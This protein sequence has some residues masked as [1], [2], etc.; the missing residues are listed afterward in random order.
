MA[1]NAG[2][3]IGVRKNDVGLVPER[4]RPDLQRASH[5]IDHFLFSLY[6]TFPRSRSRQ[7]NVNSNAPGPE[8]D[9]KNLACIW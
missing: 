9:S 5:E 3:D 2:I 8:Y 4:S 7:R 1:F 6:H